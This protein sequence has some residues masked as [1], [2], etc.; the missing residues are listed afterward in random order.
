MLR[1]S[2]EIDD[3]N[4]RNQAVP[5]EPS[6]GGLFGTDQ[7]IPVLVPLSR[8]QEYKGSLDDFFKSPQA[9]RMNVDPIL[10]QDVLNTLKAERG[11]TGTNYSKSFEQ[12]FWGTY[13][14]AHNDNMTQQGI[15][16]PIPEPA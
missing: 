9:T 13:K 15:S 11:I 8:A 6:Q 10:A 2:F 4:W 3:V 16:R 7:K 12:D 14:Q 1:K 5:I